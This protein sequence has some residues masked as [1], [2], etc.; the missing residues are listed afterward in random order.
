[1]ENANATVLPVKSINNLS[2]FS[3]QPDTQYQIE[4][5]SYWMLYYVEQGSL[6]LSFSKNDLFLQTN[7][8]FLIP[9]ETPHQF[10]TDEHEPS[11]IMITGLTLL[12]KELLMPYINDQVLEFSTLQKQLLERIFEESGQVYQQMTHN[13]F[14]TSARLEDADSLSELL[15]PVLLSELLIMLAKE[16]KAGAKK[17]TTHHQIYKH[18][19]VNDIIEYLEANLDQNFS[20]DELAAHFYISPS[21]LK[22]VFKKYTSYSIINFFRTMKMNK[23]KELMRESEL[24][25]TDIGLLLGYDSVHHFSNTFKKYTG[26]CPSSYKNSITVIEEKLDQIN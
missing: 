7:Q 3:F 14:N 20:I 25:V 9:K 11:K 13:V 23:A 4:E 5:T 12:N 19:L 8:A 22:K 16:Q 21:Y 1:M 18:Q 15:L 6:K 10:I 24:N 17:D 26:L 2:K